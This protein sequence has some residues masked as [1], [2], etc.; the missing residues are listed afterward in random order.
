MLRRFSS[1]RWLIAVVAVLAVAVLAVA[2]LA[3]RAAPAL[4]A[5]LVLSQNQ[6]RWSAA[7][8]AH[9][10]YTFEASC[11]CPPDFVRPIV[12]EVRQGAL[13]AARYRD[14]GTP[15]RPE[16]VAEYATIDQLFTLLQNA[17]GQRGSRLSVQYD[18]ELGYPTSAGIDYIPDAVDD[19]F[20]F[21]VDSFERLP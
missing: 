12:I 5:N 15:V 3:W 2:V 19:E 13:V 7:Q 17:Y 14:D 8:L 10:R 6:A 20:A 4:R 11:F 1:R 9:Y 21:T 18:Q 16:I